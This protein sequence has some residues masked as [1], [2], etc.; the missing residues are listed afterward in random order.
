MITFALCNYV[1]IFTCL[2]RMARLR[3]EKFLP[4]PGYAACA[5]NAA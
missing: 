3:R 1:K 4:V 2:S 5:A